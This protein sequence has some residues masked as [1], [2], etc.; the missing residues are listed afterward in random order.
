MT[1]LLIS[2]NLI[3]WLLLHVTRNIY[4]SEL[5]LF[6][7]VLTPFYGRRVFALPVSYLCHRGGHCFFFNVIE[8][9]GT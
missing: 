5:L 9:R 4:S 2:I 6:Y 1:N 7:C 3:S 8:I